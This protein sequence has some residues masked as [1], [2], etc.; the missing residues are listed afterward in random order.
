VYRCLDL[1]THHIITQ[2]AVFNEDAFHL[3]SSSPPPDLDTLL[4]AD[5]FAA[6]YLFT[7]GPTNTSRATHGP[8]AFEHASCGLT[9]SDSAM[10]G[11]ATFDHTMCGPVAFDRAPHD[12]VTLGRARVALYLP[13][14]MTRFANLASVYQR[15]VHHSPSV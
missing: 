13:A 4:D 2:H 5:P 10:F 6:T 3:A 7:H 15:H 8:I 14:P 12:T 1:L 11:P 9:A